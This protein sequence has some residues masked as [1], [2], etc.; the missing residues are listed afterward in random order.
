MSDIYEK[1]DN[2]FDGYID[3]NLH[4]D[5]ENGDYG[6]GIISN[7]LHLFFQEIELALKVGPNEIWGCKYS[8][9]LSKY[10]FNQY[11]TVDKIQRE[12]NTF[13]AMN[14]QHA[15]V[16]QYDITTEI[17]KIDNKELIY[18]VASIYD[19]GTDKSFVQKF[20]LGTYSN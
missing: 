7:P 13:I 12:I 11:I 16:F 18:I 6:N 19:N 17:L 4:Y 2:D 20:L 15:S 5:G 1:S 3:F 10:L 14:C 9:E 8:I